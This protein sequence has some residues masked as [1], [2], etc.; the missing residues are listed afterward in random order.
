[1][2]DSVVEEVIEKFQ[3]RSRVG[4][5]KYG[6]TLDRGDLTPIQ[7]LNHIQEELM[8]AILYAQRLRREIPD[9]SSTIQV[10]KKDLQELIDSLSPSSSRV[11]ES[12][13]MKYLPQE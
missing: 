11:I 13:K 1:M 3:E 4:I 10:S 8:D 2:S 9:E 12:F 7:W 6:T 5:E